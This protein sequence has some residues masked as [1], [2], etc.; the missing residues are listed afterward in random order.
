MERPDIRDGSMSEFTER[1]EA[2]FAAAVALKTVEERAEYLDRACPDPMLRREVESL[3]A[4]HGQPDPIFEQ[5]N[6]R[7]CCSDRGAS[8][9]VSFVGHTLDDKYRLDRLLGQ[10]GMGAVYLSTHVGTGRDVAVKLIAPELMRKGEFFQRFKREAR[11][12]GRLRH[13]NIV[14]VTDFGVARVMDERVAYLVMEYLDGC[15]LSDVLG[16]EKRLPLHWVVDIMDQVCAAVHEAHQQGIIHRDLKPANIWLEPNAQGGYRVKVLDFGIAKLGDANRAAAPSDDS[17]WTP[18]LLSSQ[19]D[20]EAEP[21]SVLINTESTSSDAPTVAAHPSMASI[22][23][24]ESSSQEGEE[25]T[26]AG[27]ILGT[28]AYMSPEQCRGQS[29]DARSDIYSLGLIAYQMLSGTLPFVGGTGSL[30]QAHQT[31]EPPHLSDYCKG[32]PT[33]VSDL[34]MS[35]LA[36]DL[37]ARPQTAQAFAHALRANS[38][39]LGV[40]YRRAFALLSGYFPQVLKLSLLAHAPLVV[41]TLI[42]MPLALSGWNLTKPM[43]ISLEIALGLVKGAAMFVTGSIISG[44]M[45]IIVVGLATAPLKPVTLRATLTILRRRLRPLLWS[46][47]LVT[48]RILIGMILLVV[49]GIVMMVRYCLWSPVVLLEELANG[50]ALARARKLAARSWRTCIVAVGFQ[51]LVPMLVQW[52]LFRLISPASQRDDSVRMKLVGEF[53]NLCS[54]IFVTP[55][56]SIVLTLVYLKMRQLSGELL[57]H[58]PQIDVG[59]HS[60]WEV[61]VRTGFSG[62]AGGR[63]GVA[64]SKW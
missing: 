39:D 17:T 14:D 56:V 20:L 54:S 46:G 1:L 34:I 60:R 36:K 5:G 44:M 16:E 24:C 40:L 9:A 11:A 55:L 64:S 37:T 35:A 58:L 57:V 30:L 38:E 25:L 42:T 61:R 52:T 27:A 49:P 50:P 48:V 51:V 59:S 45:A 31:S 2:L 13:P 18:A 3:V 28:P 4:C 23:P 22:D 12:A 19:S 33:A 6:P 15:T 53:T 32:V 47:L 10:G 41:V 62:R 7:A 21:G 26:R 8:S 63:K 29:L 43:S